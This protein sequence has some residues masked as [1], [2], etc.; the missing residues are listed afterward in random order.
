MHVYV[1]RTL[2]SVSLALNDWI[3]V[4]SWFCDLTMDILNLHLC[5]LHLELVPL[6]QPIMLAIL[7]RNLVTLIT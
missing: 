3:L 6:I 5:H 7:R 2:C 1:S 4:P